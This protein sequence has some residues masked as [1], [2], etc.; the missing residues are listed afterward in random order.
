MN[1]SRSGTQNGSATIAGSR[2]CSWPAALGSRRRPRLPI[3]RELLHHPE[4][5]PG[6][7]HE[8]GLVVDLGQLEH[9]RRRRPPGLE[10]GHAPLRGMADPALQR[11]RV[12]RPPGLQRQRQARAPSA[13]LSRARA[14]RSGDARCRRAAGTPAPRAGRRPRSSP[15]SS[16]SVR[17]SARHGDR[18]TERRA[19]RAAPRSGHRLPGPPRPPPSRPGRRAARA[20]PPGPAPVRA[21]RGLSRSRS[22]CGPGGRAAARRR[23]PAAA[24]DGSERAMRCAHDLGQGVAGVVGQA[25]PGVA[26][27]STRAGSPRPAGRPATTPARSRARDRRPDARAEARRG[28]S[29]PSV[30]KLNHQLLSGR[31]RSTRSSSGERLARRRASARPSASETSTGY[32]TLSNNAVSACARSGSSGTRQTRASGSQRRP[33][34]ERRSSRRRSS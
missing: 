6:R 27:R 33:G 11:C 26:A 13:R 29:A 7:E 24:T 17:S 8:R 14:T 16:S 15:A 4:V 23:T 5:V 3:A 25:Q 28:P 22:S 18:P 20:R 32:G 1:R 30:A 34:I 21:A 9:R 19:R 12:D 2:S 10:R 31:A